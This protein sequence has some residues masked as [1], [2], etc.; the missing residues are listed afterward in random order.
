MGPSRG[1]LQ[2]VLVLAMLLLV[3]TVRAQLEPDDNYYFEGLDASQPGESRHYNFKYKY[4]IYI[5]LCDNRGFGR[6]LRRGGHRLAPLNPFWTA[7]IDFL[8][9]ALGFVSSMAFV[10]ALLYLHYIFIVSI[11]EISSGCH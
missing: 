11:V 4:Y 10:F 3:G 9:R 5:H 2:L 1:F 7:N 6:W 8:I